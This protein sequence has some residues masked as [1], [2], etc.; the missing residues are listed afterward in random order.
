M[1]DKNLFNGVGVVIDDHV[2]NKNEHND[3]IIQL[4][5]FLENEK[6]LPLVKYV[7]LPDYIDISALLAINFLLLDWDLSGL[8][9]DFGMPISSPA[10]KENA[11]IDN[12]KF[13]KKITESVVVPI[14]IFSNDPVDEIKNRLVDENILGDDN[15]AGFPIF[16]KRKSDLFD[17][18]GQCI[19]FD[20][21]NNWLNTIPSI[22]VTQKWKTAYLDA[23]NGMALDMRTASPFWPNLL[24]NC[25]TSDGV[26]PSEEISSLINQNALSRIQPV[27][28]DENILSVK[29]TCDEDILKSLLERQRFIKNEYR[30]NRQTLWSAYSR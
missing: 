7:Q 13:I 16:I 1:C 24:W 19:M 10:L 28:F 26:N 4:V 12:I 21:I 27:E 3:K 11:I 30:R 29:K 5:D 22:Y 6:H 18:S 14:F 8:S 2:L 15:D 17:E 25:Y 9:D 20:L 23:I